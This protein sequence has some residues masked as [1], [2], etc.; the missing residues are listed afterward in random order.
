M[1]GETDVD[2]DMDMEGLEITDLK[3]NQDESEP[4]YQMRQLKEENAPKTFFTSLPQTQ[5]EL[6]EMSINSSDY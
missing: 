2:M 3:I 6:E 4:T 1:D 5:Q